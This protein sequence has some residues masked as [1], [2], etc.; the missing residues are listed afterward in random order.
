MHFVAPRLS[1]FQ[2]TSTHRKPQQSAACHHIQFHYG[3]SSQNY[4]IHLYRYMSHKGHCQ[5]LEQPP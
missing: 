5:E 2:L 4:Q 1:T 3:S